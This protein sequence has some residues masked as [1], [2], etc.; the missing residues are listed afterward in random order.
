MKVTI[1]VLATLFATALT[2]PVA[3]GDQD[4]AVEAHEINRLCGNIQGKVWYPDD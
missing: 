1:V 3:V 4:A 2:I